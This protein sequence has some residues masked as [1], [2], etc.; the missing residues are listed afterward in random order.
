M[1]VDVHLVVRHFQKEQGG[2]VN[3]GGKNS[4][5]GF[6]NGVENQT[7]AHQAAIHKNVD[8]VAIRSLNLGPGGK[9]INGQVGLLFAGFELSFGDA[10]AKYSTRGRDFNQFV[11]G[12]PAK[13]LVHA[14]AKAFNRGAVDDLLGRSRQDQLPTGISERIVGNQGSD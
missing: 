5:V 7:I 12:L 9:A 6:V 3:I 14:L 8:A 10:G 11:Q 4:T 2:R 1:H 13:E